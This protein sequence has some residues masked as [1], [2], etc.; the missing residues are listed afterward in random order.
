[1]KINFHIIIFT[2]FILLLST[3]QAGKITVNNGATLSGTGTITG[4]VE[5]NSGGTVQPS[6]GCLSVTNATFMSGSTLSVPIS[7][8]TPCS[9]YGQLQVNGA[10]DLGQASLDAFTSGYTLQVL[11]EYIFVD[12]DAADGIVSPFNGLSEDD[13]YSIDGETLYASYFAGDGNDFSL[14]YKFIY[15]IGGTASGLASGNSVFVQNGSDEIV[16]ITANG[17]YSFNDQLDDGTGYNV[18]VVVQPTSPNQTCSI[19]NGSGTVSG[20]AVTNINVS[21]VTDQYMIGGTVIGL[22]AGNQVAL[23]NNGGDDVILSANGAFNFATSMNDGTIYSVLVTAQP[24][25]PNQTCSVL[26]GA[27]IVNGGNVT[28]VVVEC[29]TNTYTIGGSVSGLAAGNSVTLQNNLGDDLVISSDSIFTFNTALFDQS[30]YA[31]TVLTQPDTPS[32]TCVISNGSGTLA[33]ANVSNVTVTCTV[34]QYSIGGS[35]SGLAAG[36]SVTLQN[37][38]GDDLV[39]SANGVFNFATVLDDES[40]YDVQ[41]T[42]QPTTP[43]QTCSVLNGSGTLAG[44]AVTNVAVGCVTNTYTVGGSVTGLAAGNSVTLQNNAGD[45]LVVSADGS[46]TFA[47]ALNDESAYA[48]TVSVQPDTPNQICVVTNES[49]TLAGVNITDVTVTCTVNQYSIGGS[50]SG[51]ATGNSVTLQNNAGDDLI[52]NAD[53]VFTFA[54]SL[55]DESSYD[56][57]VSVQP[58]TPNQTCT[59]TD[60]AGTLAGANITNVT[61]N[62]VTNT[63]TVGGIVTGL[64][65]G[66]SVTLQNNAGDDLVVSADGSFTFA[67][68]LNDES[69]YAVIVSVQPDTPSQTCVVTND[70]GALAGANVTDVSVTCTVNQYTI[71]GNVTGLAVGNFV[72]LQNNSG[73]DLVVSA[74]GVFTFATSMDDETAYDVQVSVQPTT[75][76]QTCTVNDG[77]GTLAG[78]NVTNVSISCSTNDYTV[79]GTVTG[80]ANGNSVTLQNNGGDDLVVAVD[81]SFTFATA[82]DD[83][84]AYAVTVSV[85]PDT[86]SQTCTV[87]NGSGS[88]AGANVTNVAVTCSVNDYMIGGALTGLATGNDV[89]L[90]NNGGDDLTLNADGAF[91]FDTAL[92]DKSAYDVTV[93]T[94]PTDPNQT[95][96]ITNGSGTLA[97]DDV[98]D[99]G[100]NCVTVQYTVGGTLTGLLPRE[101]VTIRNNDGD[102][103]TLVND[104]PF[105]FP[106]ALDDGS[107]YE[108]T[109]ESE[110]QSPI[111]NCVVTLGD[112]TIQ[113]QN[114]TD[115]DITC[116]NLDLIFRNGFD[117]E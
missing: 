20:A 94:Q 57:Q 7:G 26:N 80:L 46:F 86:P 104:G 109:V 8:N 39:V 41:V 62:C 68:A 93:L 98:V 106:T 17:A 42:V 77:A 78:A 12:N 36:N 61:V 110:P 60:G 67:T 81:G 9:G 51:L 22:A 89:V 117:D 115:V 114:V 32:Q 55:D 82:L 79:G 1:M 52:V 101:E 70:S 90:Q 44:A 102:E 10:V 27:G 35:V 84:S 53:G 108:V 23:Q 99:V 13:A 6:N 14:V 76:S 56:V 25:A 103:I 21:C 69:A 24:T 63:Y 66:N 107:A 85:Q 59:V 37:N 28:S 18:A 71:G 33:G 15:A 64:A 54:T 83:K 88:L 30:N 29:V 19:Q 16:E 111:Q 73:D 50:V 49:G 87:T 91:V 112:G 2:V 96:T 5:V 43:N 38:V 105:A 92:A 75:P 97:G 116:D 11:D 113:G 95:C 34:N 31:V 48:V 47:T 72:T 4:D 74:D 45:D 65:T 40:N 58:I 3:A 100:A